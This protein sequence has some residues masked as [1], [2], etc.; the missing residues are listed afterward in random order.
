M[1]SRPVTSR[2]CGTAIPKTVSAANSEDCWRW[3]A[4]FSL[5]TQHPVIPKFIPGKMR[6][7]ITT[8]CHSA[9]TDR[10]HTSIRT[11]HDV[12]NSPET[13][14]NLYEARFVARHARPT[15]ATCTTHFTDFV[16]PE[17]KGATMEAS[18]S[19]SATPT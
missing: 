3:G 16:G 18:D 19:D 10:N 15:F 6:M 7:P 8:Y 12:K 2:M 9:K 11:L 5:S 1:N 13:K 4:S 14:Q 17:L